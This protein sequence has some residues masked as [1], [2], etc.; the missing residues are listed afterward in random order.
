MIEFLP[1]LVLNTQILTYN[2][3]F[4]MKKTFTLFSA[5]VGIACTAYSGNEHTNPSGYNR[6]A[7][8]EHLEWMKKNDPGLETRMQSVEDAMQAWMAAN[9]INPKANAVTY[10]PTVVHVVYQTAGQN[11]ADM[12]VQQQID[13]LNKDYSKTNTD[14]SNTPSVFQSMS[15]DCQIQFCLA[16]KDPSGNATNGIVHKSTTV[17]SWTQDDAVKFT[18]QGG[19]DAWDATKYL[20]LWCC[21]LGSGLLGYAQFPGG[22]ASTDGVVVLYSSFPGP[23]SAAPY[24]LGRSATHEV[25][26]WLNLRHINGDANCGNDFV[27][28]T[29]T[30]DALHF[31]CPTHPYHVNTCSGSSNGEM[32]MNYMDYVDDACMVMFSTGQGTRMQACLSTSR[33][34]LGPAS[35]TKCSSTGIADVLPSESI[36][37]YP[38]P[39]TGEVSITSLLNNVNSMDLKVYNA[40]GEA[41][42]TRKITVPS[43][44]TKISLDNN[45]DGIYLF[46]VKTPD[47]TVT[48][49]VIINR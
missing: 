20:N 31:G 4:T 16:S 26:H 10:I 25:G 45:P 34:G 42:I 38:N 27:A 2:I 48:K 30:Q 32:F 41:V 24:D 17:A 44:E 43:A 1:L 37:I 14:W 23:P 21:N 35:L 6:C 7:T 8:M 29:P 39:S 12:Y 13:V 40:L 15:S 28:D 22:S 5:M 33:S 47:G 9:K 11:L 18:A 19:S 49:K 36:S 3:K 46:E